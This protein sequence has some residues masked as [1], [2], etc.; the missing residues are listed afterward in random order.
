MLDKYS[1]PSRWGGGISILWRGNTFKNYI[2]SFQNNESKDICS[3]P[4]IIYPFDSAR[5][6]LFH[7]M[8]NLGIGEGD[9]VQVMYYTCDAVTDVLIDLGCKIIFYDCD[10]NFKAINFK[11]HDECKLLI[12]QITFGGKAHTDIE[13]EEISKD[14][15][16][17]LLDKSLS[18]GPNDFK[19]EIDAIYPTIISFEV[20][21]S[22]TIGWAGILILPSSSNFDQYYKSIKRVGIVRDI[23]RNILLILNLY[24]SPKG[25]KLKFFAWLFL[26]LFQFHRAS[27]NSSSKYSRIHSKLGP[28]TLKILLGSYKSIGKNLAIANKNHNDIANLLRSFSVKVNSKVCENMSSPR[29]HFSLSSKIKDKFI[30]HMNQNNIEVGTWFDSAPSGPSYQ[31]LAHSENL[32]LESVNLPCHW[33]LTEDE[34]HHMK[35]IIKNFFTEN[36]ITQ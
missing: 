10:S 16:K 13:L 23:H 14:G 9:V 28:L 22:F 19:D 1:N 8:K 20:S 27:R 31:K 30:N 18:Y 12:S 33:S 32:F 17:V 4:N 6:A 7:Y 34:K 24:I 11:L 15:V 2:N 5:N 26:R 36:A 21:K 25:S 29:V 3:L 35:E